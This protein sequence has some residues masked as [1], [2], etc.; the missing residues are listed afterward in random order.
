[1]LTQTIHFRAWD[2]ALITKVMGI[3]ST[4]TQ[5][6]FPTLFL[7]KCEILK[8]ETHFLKLMSMYLNECHFREII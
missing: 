6:T 1:M 8:H 2:S 3:S 7:V 5:E 4:K